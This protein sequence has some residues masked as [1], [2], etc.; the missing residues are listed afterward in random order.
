M[1]AQGLNRSEGSPSDG[2]AEA[3]Q[4]GPE[5]G[6]GAEPDRQEDRRTG[7]AEPAQP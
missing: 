7:H 1:S 3:D 2:P 4:D 6:T 5:Q